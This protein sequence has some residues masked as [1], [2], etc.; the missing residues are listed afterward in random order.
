MKPERFIGVFSVLL[1]TFFVLFGITTGA[2][3]G[4]YIQW[5]G[6]VYGKQAPTAS[7]TT[8]TQNADIRLGGASIA[9]TQFPS[10][11]TTS[12]ASGNFIL[13][14]I[15]ASQQHY[16]KVSKTGYVTTNV[17]VKIGDV[18]IDNTTCMSDY[19]SGTGTTPT[20]CPTG[21]TCGT[22]PNP[23]GC[24][25]GVSNPCS[26]G[27]VCVLSGSGTGTGGGTCGDPN[28][29]CKP[30]SGPQ[31]V[32]GPCQTGYMC[33][34]TISGML[35]QSVPTTCPT[36][37]TCQPCPAN[38]T[39]PAD[40][41]CGSAALICMPTGGTGGTYIPPSTCSFTER[42]FAVSEGM[43]TFVESK[44]ITGIDLV[45][46]GM[47][48]INLQDSTGQGVQIDTTKAFITASGIK[49]DGTK[50]ATSGAPDSYIAGDTVVGK[51][52]L[53][54]PNLPPGS[55]IITI[56]GITGLTIP[57]V[58]IPIFLGEITYYSVELLSATSA[59]TVTGKVTDANNTP[60]PGA[61]VNAMS[62]GTG[63][64]ATAVTDSTGA[65]SLSL[66]QGS[67]KIQASAENYAMQFYP[68]S[69]RYDWASP[70]W[71]MPQSAMQEINFLLSPAKTIK[72]KVTDKTTGNGVA[73]AWVNAWSNTVQ[74]SGGA[75]TGTDGS[76]TIS[77][78]PASDYTVNVNVDGYAAQFYDNKKGMMDATPVDATQN[79]ANINFVLEKGKSIKGTV[80]DTAGSPISYMRVDAYSDST[81]SS[82]GDNT[83]IDGTYTITVAP[84]SDYR[85]RSNPQCLTTQFAAGGG[86]P[87]TPKCYPEAFYGGSGK[88]VYQWAAAVFVDVTS[89]DA[90]LID[91]TLGSGSTISG[92]VTGKDASGIYNIQVN[93]F[94][95]SGGGGSATTDASGNFTIGVTPGAGYRVEAFSPDGTYPRVMWK[96]TIQ[97]NKGV[98]G[99]TT[100]SWDQATPIDVASNITGIDFKMSSGITIS[101]SIKGSDDKAIPGVWVNAW[102]D[103]EMKNGGGQSKGDGTFSFSVPV[104][105]G[106]RISANSAQYPNV[107]YKTDNP[108]SCSINCVSDEIASVYNNATVFNFTAAEVEYAMPMMGPGTTQSSIKLPP[109]PDGAKGVDIKFGSSGGT[110]E[111][112]VNANGKAIAGVWVNAWSEGCSYGVG[113]P[114]KSDGTYKM[115]VLAGGCQYKV[116]AFTDK[117]IRQF[118]NNKFD[119]MEATPVAVTDANKNV[120]DINFNLSSGNSISGTV[121][122]NGKAVSQIWVNAFSESSTMGAGAA[123][124]ANGSYTIFVRPAKDY[125]VSVWHPDYTPQTY[126][127]KSD[128]T[129]ADPVDT[130]A[131]SQTGINFVLST[132]NTIS[133][134]V[135]TKSGF[136]ETDNY[137][138]SGWVNAWSE[139]TG[140]GGG[141]PVSGT[142][143][144]YKIKVQPAPDYKVQVFHPKYAPMFYDAAMTPEEA[145][146][147][148]AS[149]TNSPDKINFVLSSGGTIKG[150][151]T[152][153]STGKPGV[154]VN[155]FS[156][157]MRAG[158]GFNTD[159]SGNYAISG[160]P[161]GP[162]YKVS[163]YSPEF[164]NMFYDGTVT[165]TANW[166]LA[167]ELD[168]TGGLT[169]EGINIKLGSGGNITGTIK[170]SGTLDGNIFVDAFSEN[171]MTGRGEPVKYTTGAKEATFTIKG[172]PST[173]DYKVHVMADKYG[174]KF[175]KAGNANGTNDFMDA[176]AVDMP[177]GGNVLLANEITLSMGASIS[178]TIYS[179]ATTK[180]VIRSGWVQAMNPT[181]GEYQG[182]PI[183]P[184]GTYDI[185]GLTDGNKYTVQ[186]MPEGY[187]PIFYAPTG[188]SATWIEPNVPAT[189][190][191]TKGIDLVASK[192][193]TISG[194][195]LDSS[196]KGVPY[197]FIGIFGSDT[198]NENLDDNPFFWS[199]MSDSNGNYKTPPL[200]AG[201][202]LIQATAMKGAMGEGVGQDLGK[203]F[204]QDGVEKVITL[205]SADLSGKDIKFL[206]ANTKG[207]ISGTIT[208]GTTG[209][210][211]EI[212]I[213]IFKD[214][215]TG[216]MA[217]SKNKTDL[218]AG[219]TY[220]Y[221]FEL[222]P[223]TYNVRALGITGKGANPIRKFYKEGTPAGVDNKSDATSI[224]VNATDN[225]TG[226]DI[227]LQ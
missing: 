107:F 69:D 95:Q 110:I 61:T 166:Q 49:S 55:T 212:Q 51:G 182:T 79:I 219:G 24:N 62:E 164:A 202:Y 46:S 124:D 35:V 193:Y 137:G 190:A 99:S 5:K 128:F 136:P 13:P 142:D 187:T 26:S 52:V 172:L 220:A 127:Q 76:Y 157:K 162:G 121:T 97:D 66:S 25:A 185:K 143:G 126:N 23:A 216:K 89:A 189:E 42:L 130:T 96:G 223:G 151:I 196:N 94:S 156:E 91:I 209:D 173:D 218:L 168:L 174:N 210:F 29:S 163:I 169:K 179:D 139:S 147:V 45:S 41:P 28:M 57:A 81:G 3:A 200:P 181:A 71:I 160:L 84:A 74:A 18:D 183:K 103:T 203:A 148:N 114:S 36:G 115:N 70:L 59:G 201:Q 80:K 65:F 176:T 132:G 161:A 39:C 133:G 58:T 224:P 188:T 112:V 19:G 12:D 82:A 159:A 33:Q 75:Q 88:T 170:S 144:T 11:K 37:M 72:G 141:A 106:Y 32:Q 123:T 8:I 60:I 120:K 90:S 217:H 92:T 207:K 135:T 4:S 195:V 98:N 214:G 7:G 40:N 129:Q 113:E 167:T 153:G 205:S 78:K 199:P 83:K 150:T 34:Q 38:T 171:L 111:G 77:V 192:G 16:F 116:E 2:Q 100:T 165:G 22:C 131:G 53:L 125:K 227:T 145:T 105:S 14:G 108:A 198:N 56:E 10:V 21:Y 222:E 1:V 93:A 134:T 9:I 177:V 146:L 149:G 118:Y 6:A 154:W 85:V 140:A 109:L 31:C 27:Q 102:S 101:G 68:N 87:T 197:A 73:N 213:M 226:K 117:Y 175:Y 43:K 64:G 48:V 47:A 54:I 152:E 158:M 50:Y 206:A 180:A 191:G 138:N 86:T 204:Y 104:G 44:S 20:S 122:A 155:A 17:G 211:A 186:A 208:N 63:R 178:G 119:W 30:C 221:E 184:D 67:Y 225:L 15:P 215:S 194:Q